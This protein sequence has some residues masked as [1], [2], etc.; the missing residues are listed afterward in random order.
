MIFLLSYRRKK[1]NPNNATHRTPTRVTLRAWSLR[2]RH[3]SRHGQVPVIADVRQLIMLSATLINQIAPTYFVR[4]GWN[5]SREETISSICRDGNCS[6]QEAIEIVET[7]QML[8]YACFGAFRKMW[9]ARMS[10]LTT[11]H[12]RGEPDCDALIDSLY[13]HLNLVSKKVIIE[14]ASR[15]TSK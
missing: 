2:S 7:I 1:Y 10:S 9:E 12:D 4:Y 15:L 6:R 8:V 5:T 3:G 14:H 13:P 11:E